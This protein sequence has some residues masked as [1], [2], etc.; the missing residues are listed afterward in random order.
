MDLSF[1]NLRGQT[2][3]EGAMG[4]G[5]RWRKGTSSVLPKLR[6][7]MTASTWT[8]LEITIWE[9]PAQGQQL[10]PGAWMQLKLPV[11]ESLE[12]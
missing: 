6:Q 12:G 10:K 7:E 11:K 8:S 4:R 2:C 5:P 3:R 1:K 9:S